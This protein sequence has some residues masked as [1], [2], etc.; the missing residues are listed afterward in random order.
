[1]LDEIRRRTIRRRRRRRGGRR[2]VRF[3]ARGRAAKLGESGNGNVGL[4]KYP[5]R[6]AEH[7]D[8]GWRRRVVPTL[9]LRG[10]SIVP[11]S[12]SLV[13][14][15]KSEQLDDVLAVGTWD[16]L[17]QSNKLFWFVTKASS[18]LRWVVSETF[19]LP[20]RATET[21]IRSPRLWPA[22]PTVILERSRTE[23][24][25]AETLHGGSY[26]LDM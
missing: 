26:Q 12:L 23:S 5:N 9:L 2:R 13:V 15:V 8:H 17:G 1:M 14:F 6:V 11:S 24:P 7:D 21:T 20:P 16:P 4:E 3:R 18:P 25:S 22:R 19:L 10:T